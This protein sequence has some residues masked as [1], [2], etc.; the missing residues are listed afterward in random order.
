M[1]RIYLYKLASVNGGA[2]CVSDGLLS[3]AICKPMI[4]RGAQKGD[5]LVGVAA[6]SVDRDN[7]LVYIAR[8]NDRLADGAYYKDA[9]YMGRGDCIYEWK[10]DRYAVRRG[11]RY[12]GSQEDLEHDLGKG[13]GYARAITLL[14]WEFRYFAADGA[15]DY[16]REYPHLSNAVARLGRGH[17][18]NHGQAVVRELET[19][20]EK[21]LTM[22]VPETAQP[23]SK[24][25]GVACGI[26]PLQRMRRKGGC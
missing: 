24:A 14:S 10:V 19:M 3:L 17:R 21:M 8:V 9:R 5:L 7:R 12:H 15:D 26:M 2:P 18:V 25:A 4:R 20:A 6:N 23:A 13:P 11:A 22:D 16:R 1:A